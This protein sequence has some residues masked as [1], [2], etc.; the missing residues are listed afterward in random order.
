MRFR[1]W[2]AEKC[3]RGAVDLRI[4]T[5][6][7]WNGK[8]NKSC[9]F[10]QQNLNDSYLPPKMR[11]ERMNVGDAG[12]TRLANFIDGKIRGGQEEDQKSDG[13]HFKRYKVRE[14]WTAAEQYLATRKNDRNS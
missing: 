8:Q 13:E 12:V 10:F 11:F 9:L 5:E 2:R 4:P 1:C 7:T 6:H 3:D 14:D